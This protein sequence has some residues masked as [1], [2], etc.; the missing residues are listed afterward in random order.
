M[1]KSTI[2]NL[3]LATVLTTVWCYVASCTTVKSTNILDTHNTK[4]LLTSIFRVRNN[5]TNGS[6]TAIPYKSIQNKD[7][8][9]NSYTVYFLTANHGVRDTTS[10]VLEAVEYGVVRA[11]YPCVVLSH[12]D[13]LDIAVLMIEMYERELDSFVLDTK[14]PRQLARVVAA[15]CALA[16]LPLFSTGLVSHM[17]DVIGPGYNRW[18][19][20]APIAPGNSGGA[21]IDLATG[22]V[23]GISTGVML[24]RQQFVSLQVFHYH[25]FVPTFLII[26]WL[27]EEKLL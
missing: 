16:R 10:V 6:Q 20:S 3:A 24:V 25:I 2:I 14:E 13:G 22:K 4:Q 21:V 15:G 26:P 17:T 12:S 19:C 23:I 5:T 8:Y 11:S 18:V 27:K 9:K 1:A 7:G